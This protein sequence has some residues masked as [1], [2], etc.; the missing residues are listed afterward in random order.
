MLELR[1]RRASVGLDDIKL[2]KSNAKMPEL[3]AS[4]DTHE[5]PDRCS[6]SV[7]RRE[8]VCPHVN[9]T[10]LH[11][12]EYIM[13]YFRSCNAGSVYLYCQMFA[14]LEE[15]KSAGC[16]SLRTTFFLDEVAGKPWMKTQSCLERGST[17]SFDK[18]GR[19]DSIGIREK[20][21]KVPKARS[22]PRPKLQGA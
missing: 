18:L 13:T 14:R 2:N 6:L 8:S 7:T 10:Q 12:F 20:I 3:L 9:P 4:C 16:S 11:H 17:S 21:I 1:L 5:R 19:P 22:T 15:V